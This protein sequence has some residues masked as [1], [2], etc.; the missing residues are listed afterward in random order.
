[1]QKDKTRVSDSLGE[2]IK[3]MYLQCI[4]LQEELLHRSGHSYLPLFSLQD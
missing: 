2:V 1:M 4:H 3:F